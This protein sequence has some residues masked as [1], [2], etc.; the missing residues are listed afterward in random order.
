LKQKCTFVEKVFIIIASCASN[1]FL[2]LLYFS[3]KIKLAMESKKPITRASI[4]KEIGSIKQEMENA[5]RAK[6][7]TK[8]GPLQDK[9][10]ELLQKQT[11]IP[12]LE[13][14]RD[15]VTAAEE[16]MSQAADIR[17]FQGAVEA[18]KLLDIAKRKLA[19]ALAEEELVG[20]TCD[21]VQRDIVPTQGMTRSQLEADITD[22]WA[23]ITDAIT[24][25]DFSKANNLQKE[26]EEKESLRSVY[27]SAE[28][29][30]AQILKAKANIEVFVLKRDFIQARQLSD[31]LPSLEQ[32]LIEERNAVSCMTR[33][34]SMSTSEVTFQKTSGE[35]V[36]FKTRSVLEDEIASLNALVS[37]CVAQRDFKRAESLQRDVDGLVRLRELLP[38]LRELQHQLAVKNAEMDAA[39]AKSQ[40]VLADELHRTINDINEK[41]KIEARTLPIVPIVSSEEKLLNVASVACNTKPTVS[42]VTSITKTISVKP[43]QSVAEVRK[44]P[45]VS[46]ISTTGSTTQQS[47]S[48][49]SMPPNSKSK[50][51]TVEKLR[52]VAPLV[53]E[54]SQTI[55]SVAKLLT[56]RR[57]NACVI[58][59]GNGSL[60]GIVTDTDMTRRVIAKFVDPNRTAV[61]EIMTPN[62]TCVATT[63]SAMDALTTMVENHFRHLPVV[64]SSGSVVGL[65]DIAKCLDDAITKLERRHERNSFKKAENVAK[66]V[67]SLQGTSQATLQALLS[68]ILSKELVGQT[69]ATLRG[70]LAGKP[71]TVVSPKSS[72]QDAGLL[73]AQVRK[74]ALIVDKGVL[75]GV[76]TFKDMM[77]RVLA[78]DLSVSTTPVSEVMTP[79]PETV[80]PDISV[81]EALQIMHDQRFLTLPVCEDDGT[82]VGLVDVMDVIYGS[83]GTEGWRSIFSSAME[84][85]DDDSEAGSGSYISGSEKKS[86]GYSNTGRREFSENNSI[87]SRNTD[88]VS[89]PIQAKNDKSVAKLRPTSPHLCKV[90]DSILSAARLLK[91]QRGSACLVVNG[92]GSLA[93]ILTDTDITRRVVA[94]HVDPATTAVSLVMTRDPTCVS[95]SDSATDALTIMVE[96]HFRHLP[97][98]D[99]LGSVVGLLDIAKCLHDAISKL[100][101]MQETNNAVAE[102]A[103][104]KAIVEQGGDLSQVEAMQGLL[105]SLI[106]QAFGS[107]TTPTLRSLLAGKPSTIVSPNASIRST[108]IIMGDVRKAALVVDEG[109][110]V[111][112][113]S[114]KD[115]M[116]RAVAAQLEL[117]TTPISEV[118][119]P[120]P[121]SVSPDITILEA[122]QIMHDQHF[123]TLPVCEEN[124][125][126]VGLVDV[127]DVIYGCG[128]ADG[129]RSIF[130]C[131][132]EFDDSTVVG[133]TMSKQ[134]LSTPSY[135]ETEK[136]KSPLTSP[137]IPMPVPTTLEFIDHDDQNSFAGSTIGDERG[138]SKLMSPDEL[139]ESLMGSSTNVIAFKVVC[140]A[141]GSS[142]RIRCEP[143]IDDLRLAI[144]TKTSIAPSHMQVEYEDDEGDKVRISSDDDVVEA[145]NLSRRAGHKLAKLM[146]VEIEVKPKS[147]PTKVIIGGVVVASILGIL[148]ITLMRA[149]R[150]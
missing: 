71:K 51:R 142:H 20:D 47:V 9:I 79:N 22:I 146:V 78:K 50:S 93:G 14:L 118:M 123:L 149:K 6:D 18:Q 28:E 29:L 89:A 86:T 56:T 32:K 80:S 30:H 101:S 13:Q 134:R 92:D 5:I 60:A 46:T 57:G 52:P 67:M 70:V 23:K 113:F 59:D 11:E 110:L 96:N 95:L 138:V 114:F 137:H 36:R 64:D 66:Q 77:T 128:G 117:E 75:V 33:T 120:Y 87:T 16:K 106:S 143:K 111:G 144:S 8:C 31:T 98:V 104:H 133:S 119:T 97:V 25:K 99:D 129:W 76:F 4:A 10:D 90:D 26:L 37:T 72:I 135:V 88:I 40:F 44:T 112:I 84:V 150:K 15:A 100:E 105:G 63:D 132:M 141:K 49:K 43:T 24:E 148:G 1:R 68:N 69:M 55:I 124:G 130:R 136:V 42:S 17:D 73:M 108:G 82:V 125:A 147:S 81:L 83:G 102:S 85:Q 139:S 2:E 109:E 38:S 65:L 48:S 27:P 115:C 19:E 107:K 21:L 94:K 41:I 74:A 54:V 116:T 39:V 58:I 12:S 121:E 61:S 103:I 126:V 91:M 45:K 7:F 35:I 53:G 127:M 62:P 122:L 34:G 3:D 140:L 131:S 145:Y